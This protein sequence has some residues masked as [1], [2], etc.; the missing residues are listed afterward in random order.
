LIIALKS[1]FGCFFLTGFV[2]GSSH[3][4]DGGA[5]NYQ[6]LPLKPEY[7][8]Y[9]GSTG[10]RVY[11][12]EYETGSSLFPNAMQDHNVP[13]ARCFAPTRSATLMIPAKRT[14]PP[15]WTKVRQ[16]QGKQ[17]VLLSIK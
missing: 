6:C 1:I 11:G 16:L 14:C 8:T 9:S 17:N 13:C 12:A 7:S 4:H 5:S 2:I 15:S 10:N 3:V